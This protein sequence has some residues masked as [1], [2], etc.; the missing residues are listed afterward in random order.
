MAVLTLNVTPKK[1]PQLEKLRAFSQIPAEFS[2]TLGRTRYYAN[3]H[4]RDEGHLLNF[5]LSQ[6]LPFEIAPTQPP[7]YRGRYG[8]CDPVAALWTCH[9][10][11]RQ[12]GRTLKPQPLAQSDTLPCVPDI[13][14]TP[15]PGALPGPHAATVS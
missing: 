2:H 7:H 15:P 13:G 9:F 8:R 5:H 10:P 12:G 11:P 1:C 14:M 3:H 4:L 6:T